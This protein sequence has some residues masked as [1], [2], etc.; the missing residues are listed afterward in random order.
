MPQYLQDDIFK[1]INEYQIDLG[2][3]F[4]HI[5]FNEMAGCWYEFS[6]MVPDLANVRDPF[7][8]LPRCP[9]QVGER[10]WLWFVPEGENH[11][12]TD[13]QLR[14]AL[15]SALTWAKNKRLRTVITNGIANI[16]HDMDTL[17]N[18]RS[19]DVRARLLM[20][21]AEEN[22]AESGIAITLIS[23]NDVFLRNAA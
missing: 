4:G 14:S 12:L 16:H 7:L 8:E 13:L 3:V 23:L 11:G 5:G 9:V 17:V 21:Y 20:R 18:R 22:E 1:A 19:D 2:I 6:Q 15:K 10:Q